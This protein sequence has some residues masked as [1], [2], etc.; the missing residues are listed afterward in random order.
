MIDYKALGAQIKAVRLDRKMTQ[1]KLAEAAGVGVTHMSHIETGNSMASLQVFV[2]I[3]NTLDCSADEL[4]CL[5]VKRARPQ[6]NSWLSELVAD[7][8]EDESKLIADTVIA[9]KAS[10][11]RL[12]TLEHD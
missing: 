6:L 8:D 7:C 2:D 1:E 10:L 12:K 4:M 5:E 11:R 9:L 3:L